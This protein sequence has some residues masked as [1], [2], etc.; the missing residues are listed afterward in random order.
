MKN[1]VLKKY[2][3]F[4]L[5]FIVFFFISFFCINFL[6][7]SA[8]EVNQNENN[9]V[10]EE[11]ENNKL[12]SSRKK[13]FLN[14]KELVCSDIVN[15]KTFKDL[16]YESE[17]NGSKNEETN[18]EENEE[19]NNEVDKSKYIK[20][21]VYHEILSTPFTSKVV[22]NVQLTNFTYGLMKKVYS[23]NGEIKLTLSFGNMG[24]DQTPFMKIFMAS[25]NTPEISNIKDYKEV[26][27]VTDFNN[28]IDYW[29]QNMLYD[30]EQDP[31]V[32]YDPYIKTEYIDLL[33]YLINDSGYIK[34]IM[35]FG[36]T[37]EDCYKTSDKN[38]YRE[39]YLIIK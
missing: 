31:R 35:V 7:V 16:I 30:K 27:S 12:I 1:Y 21:Y 34:F 3:F 39:R 22:A 5:L 8:E 29:G 15:Q 4:S 9:E 25:S 38:Y 26:V 32:L 17:L 2:L 24:R 20:N 6:Q 18:K 19:N 33:E 10:E 14:G 13:L 28:F 11:K 36:N 37:E 23:L